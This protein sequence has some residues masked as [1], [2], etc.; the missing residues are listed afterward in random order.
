M[1]EHDASCIVCIDESLNFAARTREEC[2]DGIVPKSSRTR[3]IQRFMGSWEHKEQEQR[4]TKAKS[5]RGRNVNNVQRN[6]CY[7]SQK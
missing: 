6:S 5:K 3:A 2:F 1:L 4:A 7:W